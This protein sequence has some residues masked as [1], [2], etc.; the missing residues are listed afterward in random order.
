MKTRLNYTWG[1]FWDKRKRNPVILRR[2]LWYFKQKDNKNKNE[3]KK[4]FSGLLRPERTFFLFWVK[5]EDGAVFNSVLLFLL[6]SF[7]SQAYNSEIRLVRSLLSDTVL[8]PAWTH[9]HCLREWELY[10]QIIFNV[11][12]LMR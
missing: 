10:L 4:A 2:Y 8:R 1:F 9:L 5:D 3:N 6:S 11:I 7:N 12:Y